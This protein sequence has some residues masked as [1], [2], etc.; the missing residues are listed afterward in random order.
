MA[1]GPVEQGSRAPCWVVREAGPAVTSTDVNGFKVFST[2]VT[3]QK[4][5]VLLYY[6]FFLSIPFGP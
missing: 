5:L 2:L 1:A 6:L 3:I 4:N